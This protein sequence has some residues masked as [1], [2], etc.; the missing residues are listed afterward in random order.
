MTRLMAF[1]CFR[2]T[3][4]SWSS[5][6]IVT[7]RSR[8]RRI[9]L[10]LIGLSEIMRR[11]KVLAVIIA[12]LLPG[13]LTKGTVPITPRK[14]DEFGDIKC[15]DEMARLDNFAIQLLHDTTTT[16]VIIFY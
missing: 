1:R 15:E 9:F 8:T 13:I 14:F 11:V 12:L 16:G 3:A 4:R 2:R 5:L 7:A 6:R 10:L